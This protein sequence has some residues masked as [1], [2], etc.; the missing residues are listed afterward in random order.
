MSFCLGFSSVLLVVFVVAFAGSVLANAPVVY[1]RIAETQNAE[2]DIEASGRGNRA[3]NYTLVARAVAADP[4]LAYHAPRI[5]QDVSVYSGCLRDSVSDPYAPVSVDEP[6]ASTPAWMYTGIDD[7]SNCG[8]ESW[9]NATS[10]LGEYC[11]L[12]VASAQLLA[13]DSAREAQMGLGR[14]WTQPPISV[15][16]GA[17]ISTQLGADL[18]VEIGSVIHV[19]VWLDRWLGDSI[20]VFG[21]LTA[22]DEARGVHNNSLPIPLA[23]VIPLVVVGLVP[24]FGG[25][26][27]SNTENGVVVEFDFFWP[28]L[29]ANLPPDTPQN[30]RAA[31]SN[32]ETVDVA[33]RVVFNLPPPRVN[34][35]LDS[36]YDVIYA[37]ISA[38]GEKLGRVLPV[39]RV[40]LNAPLLAAL[41]LSQ[42]LSQFLGLLLNMIVIVLVLLSSLLIF[43][44]MILSVETKTF[45]LAVLRMLGMT[46]VGVV[47]LLA[48]Q[49]LCFG[50]PAWIF[51]LIFARL[52]NGATSAA[53][54]SFT[55][56]PTSPD[57]APRPAVV[58][59]FLGILMPL[60]ASVV[61][62]RQ[63]LSQNVNEGI[64][65]RRSQ[66]KAV[67]FQLDHSLS[68]KIDVV[69][70]TGGAL[71]AFFGFLIYYLVPLALIS[72]NISLLLNVFFLI[73]FG[74]LVG[75]V[76]FGAN[77]QRLLENLLLFLFF[78]W[79]KGV[80]KHIV[81]KNLI[82]HKKRNKKTSMLY[83][84]SLGFV[85]FVATSFSVNI[86][87]FSYAVLNSNGVY[88]A[89][90]A[91][92]TKYDAEYPI[93][94]AEREVGDSEFRVNS[95][96]NE[97]VTVFEE[98][99]KNNS[100]TV[101][102]WTWVTHS[103]VNALSSTRVNASQI[104]TVGHIYRSLSSIYGVS[105]SFRRTVI[106]GF[107][108][109]SDDGLTTVDKEFPDLD[110]FERLYTPLGSSSVILGTAV[111]DYLG[112]KVFFYRCT[113]ASLAECF[114]A[115]DCAT[116]G[117]R[118]CGHLSGFFLFFVSGCDRSGCLSF[119]AD[120][121]EI[122]S[123]C[124]W[125]C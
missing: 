35:Y 111:K 31:L 39:N 1:L 75:L 117:W 36:D 54:E 92:P 100:D 88:L 30:I 11:A 2:I 90:Y 98:C 60:L 50:V 44:L 12:V 77:L 116:A 122:K 87:S 94:D 9:V 103:L 79:E 22:E 120:V 33:Q 61:P 78:F 55:S 4:Q 17:Y 42:I 16:G 15:R 80:I 7:N 23:I 37:R 21:A 64:D 24:D 58:A 113:S 69:V 119:F 62:I 63:A 49:S 121:F 68:P 67:D 52:A 45:Q 10:C 28:H 108:K 6:P 95:F 43:S 29:I 99:L 123:R 102:S 14:S 124:F 25:K 104:E 91:E 32:M 5:Q 82:A 110:I 41:S 112:V 107:L 59:S 53:F 3:L 93:L 57:L 72:Q 34:A 19:Q 81:K 20:S 74:M 125:H 66:V 47:A 96:G 13:I 118:R 71:L 27:P 114:V 76:M 51:G 70:M 89:V 86:L 65:L 46:K 73:L 97:T 18:G 101:K 40:S 105:N 115:F 8:A 85:I 106:P 84:L 38:F 83:S 109:V 48:L 26:L 56:I